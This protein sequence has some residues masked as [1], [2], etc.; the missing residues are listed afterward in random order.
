MIKYS[1]K[2]ITDIFDTFVG[3][4]CGALL[5]CMAATDSLDILQQNHQMKEFSTN[6]LKG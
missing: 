5:A 4:S 2:K 3:V 6:I 1:K